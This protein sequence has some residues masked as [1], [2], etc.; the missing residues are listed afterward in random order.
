MMRSLSR[1][2][3]L[4]FDAIDV[5]CLIPIVCSVYDLNML[6]KSYFE[7]EFEKANGIIIF[8]MYY[9]Y[10]V[11][12]HPKYTIK[13]PVYVATNPKKIS[14]LVLQLSLPNPLKPDVK[15]RIKI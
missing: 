4:K 12:S 13:P 1:V 10:F 14:R 8:A 9:L 7:S 15:S 3:L 11:P 6:Q 5:T 2:A